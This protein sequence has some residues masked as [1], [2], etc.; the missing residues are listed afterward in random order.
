MH[1]ELEQVDLL[2]I[3]AGPAG[4]AAAIE[5]LR[6]GLSAVV[7][8]RATFPRDKCCGDGLT[9]GC[10]RHLDELGLDP[11]T[12]PSWHVVNDVYVGGPDGTTI[13]FPLPKGR[14]QFAAIARREELDHALV[15]H[16]RNLGADIREQTD[17]TALTIEGQGADQR[18]IATTTAGKISASHIIAADGMWSP[19]RKM[20]GETMPSY[21]GDWHAFRQYFSNVSP[22]AASELWVWFEPDLL[23]GYVWSFPLADGSANVGFGIQRDT[24]HKIQDMKTL[25]PD[26]LA[27]PHIRAVLGESAVPESPHKAWPIPARLGEATL[28]HKNVLWVG[29]AATATDPMTGEGIG[30]ALET[31]RLA[32]SSIAAHRNDPGA[33]AAAYTADLGASMVKD[34]RLAGALSRVLGNRAGATWSVK[35]A[36]ATGWT[37]RN[38]ARLLFED[39]PRA[40]LGTPKRWSRDMFRRDGAFRS[41]TG[42]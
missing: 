15:Q 42:H 32:V 12:V 23:P 2:I 22:Q 11:A 28:T 26:I 36:G 27:R 17:V 20:L 29:D 39:Y 37:R 3:G 16:A 7:V 18:A 8:D 24:G 9:T 14:G 6:S 34:H 31:G 21:R 25:W 19:T 10:L 4:T 13:E 33:I 38:F 1:N 35:I 40:V 41:L 30:Q 5:A